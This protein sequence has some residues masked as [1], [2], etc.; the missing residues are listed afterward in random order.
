MLEGVRKC[1]WQ[2]LEF[3]EI[4]CPYVHATLHHLFLGTQYI[5][6]LQ[7]RENQGVRNMHYY[8][9]LEIRV[10]RKLGA[11]HVTQVLLKQNRYH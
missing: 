1:T 7:L 8:L 4:Y 2:K 6:G 9:C 3:L 5:L 10:Y 11:Q